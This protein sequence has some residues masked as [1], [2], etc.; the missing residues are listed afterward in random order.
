M[1][2][3]MFRKA[4]NFILCMALVAS[5]TMPVYATP[6][7]FYSDSNEMFRIYLMSNEDNIDFTDI[8]FQV[9]S[10]ELVYSETDGDTYQYNE[11]Y[12][13]DTKAN[14]Q[15]VLE[16]ERP[17]ECFSV[18]VDLQ[19]I[20]AGYGVDK[21]TEFYQY[22]LNVAFFTIK[23]IDHVSSDA[24]SLDTIENVSSYDSE[25]NVIFSCLESTKIIDDE[26]FQSLVLKEKNL[27]IPLRVTAGEFVQTIDSN[28]QKY[29]LDLP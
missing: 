10:A 15:G 13:F 11:T 3:N 9:F 21:H 8:T 18:T 29:I 7:N 28:I 6:S 22:D 19:T 24:V 17:S 20:P 26:N 5:V 14:A 25:G 4:L 1:L 12:A 16:F 27:S 23:P 2:S